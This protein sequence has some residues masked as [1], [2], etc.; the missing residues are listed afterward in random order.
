[1]GGDGD[2]GDDDD[3]HDRHSTIPLISVKHGSHGLRSA[4]RALETRSNQP[5][6]PPSRSQG[7]RLLVV[8]YCVGCPLRSYVATHFD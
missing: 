8:L 7:P 2:L 6:G 4:Q 3:T 1:M 5:K